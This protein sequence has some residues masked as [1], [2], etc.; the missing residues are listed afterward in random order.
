[1]RAFQGSVSGRSKVGL[2]NFRRSLNGDFTSPSLHVSKQPGVML[3][4]A[5]RTFWLPLLTLL[6]GAGLSI[7]GYFIAAQKQA[8]L[9]ET[10][11]VTSSD[12]SIE[13]LR[14]N[15]HA[16]SVSL[17]ALKSFYEVSDN[18][19]RS[20]F[21]K[22][23]APLLKDH[24]SLMV[25]AWL[26]EVSHSERYEFETQLSGEYGMTAPIRE[27]DGTGVFKTSPRKSTYYPVSFG[28]PGKLAQSRIGVDVASLPQGG[29]AISAA[30]Q[31]G[32]MV[33]SGP[34]PYTEEFGFNS[35]VMIF[36]AVFDQNPA[37][38]S[39]ADSD[40]QAD[41]LGVV[42]ALFKVGNLIEKQFNSNADI[43]FFI[44]DITDPN[45]IK[46]I[47]GKAPAVYKSRRDTSF[48]FSGRNWKITSTT[49]HATQPFQWL[50]FSVLAV[51]LTF[52]I[53]VS[54]ALLSL[55]RRKVLVENLVE[56]R[57]ME[58]KETV[59]KLA[60]SNEDLARYAYVCSHDLQT[61]LRHIRDMSKFLNAH[62]EDR[63]EGDEEGQ[64][65]LDIM[66]E[67]A[68]RARQLVSDILAY[69]GVDKGTITSEEFNTEDVVDTL[70][71]TLQTDLGDRNVQI[72]RDA[73]PTLQGN[74]TQFYQLLQN[75]IK[76]GLK[77]QT[78]DTIPHVH[79]SVEDSETHWAFAVTDNGIGIAEENLD[80]VFEVFKRLHRQKEYTG[81]GVGLAICK[82]I[83][84]RNGGLIWVESELGHGSTFHFT[85]P[86][87]V[88]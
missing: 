10:R 68:E 24:P 31:S 71:K 67:S 18:I 79:I 25:Y 47:Y 51:S 30:I 41:V 19:D 84:E 34:V 6:C 66:T 42:M 5:L 75:L 85:F 13:Y 60:D 80:K 44:E 72:T 65:Y 50:P 36:N 39:A 4:F 7:L 33:A 46:T 32:G 53:F 73:L 82:K 1:M 49:L 12:K 54:L 55:I 43:T 62:L 78:P 20:K 11:F 74:R 14:A 69:S 83:V 21:K 35:N 88:A 27:G 9:Q 29:P 61:P 70:R 86:K 15:L 2:V 81:T 87:S 57:T 3:I 26:P 63:L 22:F 23:A 58:L 64:R 76:N 8:G 77:Y 28:F 38:N 17:N 16:N 52:S 40:G 56:K 48:S 45:N 59:G 37:K